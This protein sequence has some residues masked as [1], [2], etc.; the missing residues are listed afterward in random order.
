MRTSRTEC[1][2]GWYV[3]V[4]LNFLLWRAKRSWRSWR[5]LVAPPLPLLPPLLLADGAGR[6]T[7]AF[8]FD[9][10]LAA[11]CSSA[12]ACA[13]A[14]A[15]R[16]LAVGAMNRAVRSRGFCN[17]LALAVALRAVDAVRACGVVTLLTVG[18]ALVWGSSLGRLALLPTRRAAIE[19]TDAATVAV[20]ICVRMRSTFGSAASALLLSGPVADRRRRRAGKLQSHPVALTV[21]A[22]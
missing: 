19:S 8:A 18:R 10:T 12:A 15:M 22:S 6:R 3:C 1:C 7:A 17:R 13:W 14:A 4:A 21:L 2:G 16:L 9:R 20:L 11:R 5:S